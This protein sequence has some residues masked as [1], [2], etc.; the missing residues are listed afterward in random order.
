MAFSSNCPKCQKQVLVPEGICPDAVMQCP[1]CS[2]E[3]ALGEILA[4]APPALIVIHPGSTAAIPGIAVAAAAPVPEA[5][6]ASIFSAHRVEPKMHDDE[7]LLFAGDE[8]ELH[9]MPT[10]GAGVDLATPAYDAAA[11]DHLAPVDHVVEAVP[12][13]ADHAN[14]LEAVPMETAHEAGV[15]AEPFGEALAG[16]LPDEGH[17]LAAEPADGGA[18]WGGAWVGSH[19]EDKQEDDGIG[20]AEQDQDEGLDDVNFAEITG[21]AAPGSAPVG[22]L[23]AAA[24]AAE[25][26][27]KKKRK[28]ETHPFVRLIGM[29]IA[30][31]LAVVC[32]FGFAAWKGIKM[33]FLP[34]WLQFNFNKSNVRA[35][36]PKPAVQPT[37]PAN[38][39]TPAN[40]AAP[41]PEAGKANPP[42]PNDQNPAGQKPLPA[43]QGGKADETK[44]APGKQ[45]TKPATPA[46]AKPT[47]DADPFGDNSSDKPAAKPPVATP[48]KAE[49]PKPDADPF[50]P[51]PE[52]APV[53]GKKTD[54]KPATKPAVVVPD[55]AETPKPDADADPFGPG[56]E[57]A[58]VGGKKTDTKPVKPE[59]AT[60]DKAETPKPEVETDPFA[61]TPT[62]VGGKKTDA[63]PETPTPVKP[64]MPTKPE[65]PELDAK[66][67]ANPVIGPEPKPEI[68]PEL[69]PEV[70]PEIKPEI[71]PEVKPEIKPE[72]KPAAGV[73]PLQA[74]SFAAADLDTSLKAVSGAATVDAASYANWCKLAE[75]VTYVKDNADAQRQALQTLAGKVASSPQ[76]A[77][78][79]A[80]AAK[81]LLDD[82][83]AKGGIVLAGTVTTVAVR[84]GLTGTA[85]HVEGLPKS[86]MVFSSHSLDVKEN[87]KVIVFGAL[88]AE[89]KKNLPGYPGS[90]PIVVWTDFAATL[91]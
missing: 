9:P 90:Q 12:V 84:N 19:E 25:P 3:F 77:S 50:G 2:A 40:S 22:D 48:D 79:I 1:L 70:K 16:P 31:L 47:E 80:A 91:P 64:D 15:L 37:P 34:S 29:I 88:V 24:L 13:D 30:G 33:D 27:K 74:P 51:G 21:K 36:A 61:P 38:G 10:A 53:G 57:V 17:D 60:P 81:K 89:P 7:P 20:F 26:A 69:K 52:V 8:V 6:A 83:S 28:R 56:P 68:K 75:T 35:D 67:D 63:K 65:K 71:K 23:A 43:A 32:V 49:T 76:A 82:K 14:V 4:S 5:T 18:P 42:A 78:V 58:P 66:P 72:V 46:P 11:V 86:V 55:K 87:Q 62:P 45:D 41:A 39:E 73:G 44:P 59:V 85:I 54:T